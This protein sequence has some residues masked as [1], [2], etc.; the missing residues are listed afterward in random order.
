MQVADSVRSFS[1]RAAEIQHRPSGW[2]SRRCRQ[3][4]RGNAAPAPLHRGRSGAVNFSGRNP[5]AGAGVCPR[6]WGRAAGARGHGARGA[7]NSCGSKFG[8]HQK[9][10]EGPLSPL[11]PPGPAAEGPLHRARCAPAFRAVPHPPRGPLTSAPLRQALHAG[12]PAGPGRRA[13]PLICN[14]LRA[15]RRGGREPP[16]RPARAAQPVRPRRERYAAACGAEPRGRR[17]AGQGGRGIALLAPAAGGRLA[18]LRHASKKAGSPPVLPAASDRPSAAAGPEPKRSVAAGHTQR[19][20]HSLTGTRR[21]SH[22]RI[23]P[24]LT[25]RDTAAPHTLVHMYP[26]LTHTRTAS[27]SLTHTRIYTL[28]S[29]THTIQTPLAPHTHLHIPSHIP[30]Y[31]QPPHTHPHSHTPTHPHTR[32]HTPTPTHTHTRLRAWP[33][34]DAGRSPCSGESGGRPSPLPPS[35]PATP[36]MVRALGGT[37]W[38][39][40]VPQPCWH[41][42]NLAAASA[43]SSQTPHCVVAPAI[44]PSSDTQC[45]D[46]LLTWTFQPSQGSEF[47]SSLSFPDTLTHRCLNLLDNRKPCNLF[48]GSSEICFLHFLWPGKF[49]CGQQQGLFLSVRPS[50]SHWLSQASLVILG[51]NSPLSAL[52]SKHNILFMPEERSFNRGIVTNPAFTIMLWRCPWPDLSWGKLH[53]PDSTHAGA[54]WVSYS[55]PPC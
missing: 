35:S 29:Q 18:G 17:Q 40:L 36:G 30:P 14:P 11:L 26:P 4:P 10:S 7:P 3:L 15:E 13:T 33:G 44:T 22:A 28:L 37:S 31:T 39:V 45:G 20:S 43:T 12:V 6:G 55:A 9:E 23:H 5:R 38:H 53:H 49:P 42:T 54:R 50:L 34:H 25:H 21:P 47:I 52:S 19:P 48:T 46:Q 27:L 24:P 51:F 1:A 32:W 16:C 41:G 2:E 8:R